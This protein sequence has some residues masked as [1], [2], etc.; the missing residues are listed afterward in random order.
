[1]ATN[2]CILLTFLPPA[3][4]VAKVMF[5]KVSVCPRERCLPHCMLGYTPLPALGDT[6]NKR[7]VCILL[8]CILVVKYFSHL[9][10]KPNRNQNFNEFIPKMV[11]IM[12]LVLPST[13]KLVQNWVLNVSKF[14]QMCQPR[15]QTAYFLLKM[16]ELLGS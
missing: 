10:F 13:W 7:T 8:E 14:Q 3:I 2:H 15:S 1:M 6:G 16:L 9:K 4:E 12:N 5:S 11:N